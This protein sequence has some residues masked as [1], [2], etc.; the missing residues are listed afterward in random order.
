MLGEI[1]GRRAGETWTELTLPRFLLPLGGS[2]GVL[3]PFMDPDPGASSGLC[4]AEAV[5]DGLEKMGGGNGGTDE[6][7][8]E[9][10]SGEISPGVAASIETR[11]PLGKF[12]DSGS[13]KLSICSDAIAS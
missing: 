1:L 2:C 5:P 10:G 7:L 13:S 12:A 4:V 6:L 3:L 9:F 11:G 8:T